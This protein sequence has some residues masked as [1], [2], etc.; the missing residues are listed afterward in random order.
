[1][2][3]YDSRNSGKE[4]IESAAAFYQGEKRVKFTYL[5][6]GTKQDSA[7]AVD[8]IISQGFR[9]SGQRLNQ[10]WKHITFVRDVE[11]DK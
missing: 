11:K 10:E 8:L 2:L 9:Q 4:W 7:R 1:M 3:Q 5:G 6:T